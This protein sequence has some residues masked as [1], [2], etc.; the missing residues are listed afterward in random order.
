MSSP[1]CTWPAMFL[2]Q[3]GYRVLTASNVEQALELHRR[4]SENI[5]LLILKI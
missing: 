2:E 4:E 3:C 1:S 5:A